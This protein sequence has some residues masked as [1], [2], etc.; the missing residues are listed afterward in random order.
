[1]RGSPTIQGVVVVW[2]AKT[3]GPLAVM[4]S[5]T[6]NGIRAAATTVLAVPEKNR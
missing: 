2:D 4:D 1:V 3:G 5:V 6:L